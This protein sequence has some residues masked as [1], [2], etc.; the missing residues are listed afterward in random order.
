MLGIDIIDLNDLLLKE[1]NGRS[2]DFISNPGDKQIR[3][4]HLF[5]ILWT[6]KEAVF[7]AKRRDVTFSPTEIPI[8]LEESEEGIKFYSGKL[9]GTFE[10]SDSYILAVAAPEDYGITLKVFKEDTTNWSALI[11][12]KL[13]SHL[14]GNEEQFEIQNDENG[15]PILSPGNIPISFTHHGKFGAFVYP[16]SFQET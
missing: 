5:W 6:A 11:R 4:P 7:K 15:L 9:T 2:F 14:R 3:H 1:R 10:I 13:V 16:T 8:K 12:E